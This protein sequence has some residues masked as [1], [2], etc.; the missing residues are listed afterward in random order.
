MPS[1]W[2]FA[3]FLVWCATTLGFSVFIQHRLVYRAEY[4]ALCGLSY[5]I[6]LLVFT[7]AL[8]ILATFVLG[9]LYGRL[10]P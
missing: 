6:I 1:L 5:Y 4:I 8:Y 7:S 3:V 2:Q 10:Q 9:Y